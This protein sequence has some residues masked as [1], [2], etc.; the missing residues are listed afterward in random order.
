MTPAQA[1]EVEWQKPD[2]W[3]GGGLLGIYF[4]KR[5]ARLIVLRRNPKFGWTVNLAHAAGRWVA[6]AAFLIP[7][8]ALSAALVWCAVR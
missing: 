2:N 7:I 1:N 4:S 3:N 6:L 8:A 5:D